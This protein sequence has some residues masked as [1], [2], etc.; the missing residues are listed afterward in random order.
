MLVH[1]YETRHRN[2]EIFLKDE[3][4]YKQLSFIQ[5]IFTK[6]ISCAKENHIGPAVKEILW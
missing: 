4:K 5:G 1:N 3:K 2:H 6:K